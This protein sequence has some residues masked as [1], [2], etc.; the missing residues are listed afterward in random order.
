MRFQQQREAKEKVKIDLKD[1][2]ILWQL[3]QNSRQAY[4]EI[5][6]KV[7]LSNDAIKYRIQ[8]L[9]QQGVIQ[10]YRTLVDL[11]KFGY[12]SYHI[13]LTLNKPK[14]EIEEK[15]IKQFT[16]YPF[17]RAVIKF[18]GQYDFEIAIAAKSLQEFDKILNQ[19]INDSS[20]YLQ[21]YEI[22]IITKGYAAFSLPQSFYKEPTKKTL[23]KSEQTKIDKKDLEI[24]KIIGDKATIP[25][26]SIADKIKV[27]VDAVSYRMKKMLKAGIIGGFIPVINYTSLG[28]NM[29]AVLLKLQN[30]D[31]QKEA[32]FKQFLN[33]NQNILW[34]V[35]TIGKYNTIL[36]VCTTTPEG[37]HTTL[38][39]LRNAYAENIKNYETLMA[40]EEYKYTYMVDNLEIN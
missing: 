31:E 27:S 38:I 2:K 30:M 13:F 21:D 1:K 11:S 20:A 34:A 8:R 24:L 17:V 9:E 35:K 25:L 40:Y 19:I 29:Y 14:K 7:G 23:A 26:Y 3:A 10:G 22:L 39:D 16:T 4:T 15:L 6:K 36:Y 5:A 37:L 12:N 28:Y 32:S 33:T 18:S